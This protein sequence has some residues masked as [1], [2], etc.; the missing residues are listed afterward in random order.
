MET[1]VIVDGEKEGCE[2]AI[3]GPA[4]VQAIQRLL[5]ALESL[6]TVLETL[7]R[8]RRELALQHALLLPRTAVK[9]L[10]VAGRW[11]PTTTGHAR[12]AR[13]SR[14]AHSRRSDAAWF[15][16]L[17]MLR[18]RHDA[19]Q[20]DRRAHARLGRAGTGAPCSIWKPARRWGTGLI[21]VLEFVAAESI[22]RRRVRVSRTREQHRAHTHPH[23][24]RTRGPAQGSTPGKDI[25]AS[26]PSGS[27]LGQTVTK[28]WPWSATTAI[29]T[30][31]PSRPAI[32]P[33]FTNS[34]ATSID[35]RAQRFYLW[36]F[37]L[38]KALAHW[39]RQWLWRARRGWV[40]AGPRPGDAS[41]TELARGDGQYRHHR[42][43]RG[44]PG[45]PALLAEHML[46]SAWMVQGLDAIAEASTMVVS[47]QRTPPYEAEIDRV[48]GEPTAGAR[49]I[50]TLRRQAQ[51][52]P[53]P[54]SRHP[55]RA[56]GAKP[57]RAPRQPRA[58]LHCGATQG[59][60]DPRPATSSPRSTAV[61]R[62][63]R[64]RR[65]KDAKALLDALA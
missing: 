22:L 64:H 47:T 53:P 54:S 29:T 24:R 59:K 48:K 12:R 8:I 34:A 55:P 17:H 56:E 7:E 2:R 38:S 11:K 23:C 31:W 45:N 20:R 28:R 36:R 19:A 10:R 62:G 39:R 43:W 13:R 52:P 30:P 1:S 3:Q 49:G 18:A 60:L 58:S 63:L 14:I 4:T 61:H 33:F 6:E 21:Y 27:V 46:T 25:M 40:L 15:L 26:G 51:K 57:R 37:G 44:L 41:T 9:L 42:G 32:A 50:Q 35:R 65:Q 16:T 5:K